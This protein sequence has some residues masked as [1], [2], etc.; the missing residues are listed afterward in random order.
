MT[1]V[2]HPR[3]ANEGRVSRLLCTCVPAGRMKLRFV[4]GHGF[5]RLGSSSEPRRGRS[6]SARLSLSQG[7]VKRPTAAEHHTQGQG[8][9]TAAAQKHSAVFGLLP[10]FPDTPHPWVADPGPLHQGA[11][12]APCSPG[13]TRI[14]MSSTAAEAST[15]TRML[16]LTDTGIETG[17]GTGTTTEG[18][19]ETMIEIGSPTGTATAAG[20][21]TASGSSTETGR[22]SRTEAAAGMRTSAMG[23]KM[24]GESSSQRSRQTGAGPH[25]LAH[26]HS[27]STTCLGSG[28]DD[29][30]VFQSSSVA[31]QHFAFN[32]MKLQ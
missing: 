31:D 4:W 15:V 6:Q 29:A 20:T 12:T 2:P 25:C 5:C 14:A 27:S 1:C 3:A 16:H 9:T 10:G 24:T 22:S 21:G 8:H 17:I 30:Q 11:G 18:T 13:G 28:E 19:A 26:H 7:T 32:N 23:L